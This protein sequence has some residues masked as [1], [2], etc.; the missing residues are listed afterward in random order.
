MARDAGLAS[1][2]YAVNTQLVARRAVCRMLGHEWVEGWMI[3]GKERVCTRCFGREIK[4]P[5]TDGE[6]TQFH[7]DYSLISQEAWNELRHQN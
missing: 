1:L 2:P 4:G 7:T 6:F 5:L 3:V